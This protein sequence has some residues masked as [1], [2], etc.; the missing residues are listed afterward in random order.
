MQETEFGEQ[1]LR[2]CTNASIIMFAQQQNNTVLFPN[3]PTPHE[4]KLLGWDTGFCIPGLGP[5]QPGRYAC[6][7]FIQY[8]KSSHLA[9]QGCDFYNIWN[10]DYY[11]FHLAYRVNGNY[12]YH[13]RNRLITLANQGYSAIYVTNHVWQLSELHR[14]YINQRLI[15]DL[16]VLKV[17]SSLRNHT[18]VSFTATSNFFLLHS[19][20]E[21]ASK[22]SILK[23]L[24]ET[25]A[26]DYYKDILNLK[27]FVLDYEGQKIPYSLDFKKTYKSFQSV[28][29][30]QEI[31]LGL[32]LRY[33]L[34][35][36][37]NLHWYRIPKST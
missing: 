6:N 15:H 8:K 35:Y 9:G 12:D 37:M 10:Q 20:K 1:Q 14:L 22:T 28:I 30:R 17:K 13:Q 2:D 23:V 24:E 32:A 36:Q 3:S 7:L 31:A 26:S 19:E 33:Y 18:K 34:R 21:D 16:P 11:L 4:E 29:E 27:T 5:T 25:A